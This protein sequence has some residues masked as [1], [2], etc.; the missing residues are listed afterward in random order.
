MA[1]A[2][3][4]FANNHNNKGTSLTAELYLTQ[5]ERENYNNFKRASGEEQC[6]FWDRMYSKKV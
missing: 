4:D 2:Y 3:K 6:K 5:Q 1:K